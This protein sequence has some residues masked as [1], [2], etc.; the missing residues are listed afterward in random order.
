MPALFWDFLSFV[1][2]HKKFL[3][4]AK[5]LKLDLNDVDF[6]E[7]FIQ[8][9]VSVPGKPYTEEELVNYIED[10]NRCSL[11]C[12]SYLIK[13]VIFVNGSINNKPSFQ[14]NPEE[15]EATQHV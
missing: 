2:P 8:T 10:N 3:Q 15:T 11:C 9:P 12:S 13:F 14:T 4:I 7:P 5:S 1:K 6:Y